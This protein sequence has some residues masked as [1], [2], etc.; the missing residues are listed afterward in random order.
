VVGILITILRPFGFL[1]SLGIIGTGFEGVTLFML[2]LIVVYT[3]IERVSTIKTI[4]SSVSLEAGTPL[5]EKLDVIQETASLANL[6]REEGLSAFYP[7]RDALPS[8]PKFIKMAESDLLICS[9][10]A[11]ALIKSFGD[12]LEKR[13]ESGCNL[14]FLLPGKQ[15]LANE[16]AI[17]HLAPRRDIHRT[18]AHLDDALE[19][20]TLLKQ[21]A[22]ERG[23]LGKLD[24][25]LLNHAPTMGFMMLDGDKNHGRIRV[26]QYIYKCRVSDRPSYEVAPVREG[27]DVYSVMQKQFELCWEEATEWT[28]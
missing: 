17:K 18:P 22:D 12:L 23:H 7:N 25:K 5:A 21:D 26:E 2:S 11:D 28:P 24:V 16:E 20:L 27:Q 13:L 8:L 9:L 6:L 14:R 3:G 10:S 19:Y 1:N 4:K 15:V